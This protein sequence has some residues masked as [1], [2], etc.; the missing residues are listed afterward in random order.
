[1]HVA[2]SR[3]RH[4]EASDCNV[5]VKVARSCSSLCDSPWAVGHQAPLS[6]ELS[7]QE[8]WVVV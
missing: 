3:N 1:M 8:H 6:M 5:C 4:L 2:P 7:K